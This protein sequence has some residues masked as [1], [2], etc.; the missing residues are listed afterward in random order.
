MQNESARY[1]SSGWHPS[2]VTLPSCSGSFSNQ[3]RTGVPNSSP[4]FSP[5]LPPAYLIYDSINNN[6]SKAPFCPLSLPPTPP[7]HPP[8]LCRL[9]PRHS[10]PIKTV[11]TYQPLW[12]RHSVFRARCLEG[13]RP[14]TFVSPA[15][16]RSCFFFHYLRSTSSWGL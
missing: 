16:Q 10:Q 8:V 12:G 5:L 13:R 3:P 6:R 4:P 2:S 9:P 7:T 11:F 15:E 14:V 1:S